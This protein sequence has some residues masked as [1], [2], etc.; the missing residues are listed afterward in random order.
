MRRLIWCDDQAFKDGC[1]DKV[2]AL[3]AASKARVKRHKTGDKAI[4]T[5]NFE[6]RATDKR[7]RWK[8]WQPLQV[9]PKVGFLITEANAQALVPYLAEFPEHVWG[10][11]ILCD[12]G[13]T[14]RVCS[15]INSCTR[16]GSLAF[17]VV[18]TWEEA[19][20]AVAQND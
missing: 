19:L 6:K 17:A 4:R 11:V 1:E 5:L 9:R 10:I 8:G 15:H 13:D 3:E 16:G 20:V 12:T 2:A 18:A 14:Q 7:P